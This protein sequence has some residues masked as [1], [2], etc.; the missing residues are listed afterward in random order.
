MNEIFKS[1]KYQVVSSD[2]LCKSI[3]GE[4]MKVKFRK[5]FIRLDFEV[6]KALK[7][8]IV[9]KNCFKD[10]KWL[11]RKFVKIITKSHLKLLCVGHS[12]Y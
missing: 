5:Y 12:N 4:D 3:L 1:R 11:V 9:K 6:L 7:Q 10:G 2:F 8:L